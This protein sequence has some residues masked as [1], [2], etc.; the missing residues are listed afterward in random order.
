[1][2]YEIKNEIKTIIKEKK[3]TL[4]C[5]IDKN[6][7]FTLFAETENGRRS[8]IFSLTKSGYGYLYSYINDNTGLQLDSHGKL[9]IAETK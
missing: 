5:E 9:V 8:Q 1:M 2:I 4:S 7:I 3:L 6:G